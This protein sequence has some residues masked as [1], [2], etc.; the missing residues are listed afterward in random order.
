MH[1]IKI[2]LPATL[3]NLGP[4]LHTLGLAIGLYTTVEISARTDNEIVLNH[5]GEGEKSFASPLL[6]PVVRGMARFFQNLERTILGMNITVTNQIPFKS[7]LGAEM[8]LMVAGVIAANDLMGYPYKREEMVELAARFTRTDCAVTALSGGLTTSYSDDDDFYYRTLPVKPFE[9]I[10]A[11]PRLDD[12]T[13]TNLPTNIA[14]KDALYNLARTP[15]L[16]DALRQGDVDALA[17]ISEDRIYAP[18]LRKQISGYGHVAEIARRA[19]ALTVLP[20]G[21]GPALL[22]IARSG[23]R[24][25]AEDMRLAFQSAGIEAKAWVL[26][27]DTQGVVISAVGSM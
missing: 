15:L 16:I 1:K 27:V 25:I 22:A 10:I 7:G 11:A 3:T 2:R 5:H 13:P 26:P 24:R 19:G 20:I 14:L 21:D 17:R 12:Y 4:G 8:I 23:H 9:F 6:H 18:L